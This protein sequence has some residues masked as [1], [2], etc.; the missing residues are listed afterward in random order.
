MTEKEEVVGYIRDNLEKG[1]TKDQ[2]EVSLF[3]S[4]R[5][6]EGLIRRQILEIPDVKLFDAHK[7]AHYALIV[8]T[9]ISLAVR[10]Q[11]AFLEGSEFSKGFGVVAIFIS[12]ILPAIFLVGLIK[13][14]VWGYLFFS[15]F[16]ILNLF[17]SLSGL[18]LVL[19]EEVPFGE[20][21]VITIPWSFFVG[22]ISYLA[23]AIFGIYCWKKIHPEYKLK[24]LFVVSR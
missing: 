17:F 10:I 8:F 21:E 12:L 4:N 6:P 20:V 24:N 1:Y 19:S 23:L 7:K 15:V 14:R 2:I 5:Y 22:L 11:S 13:A 9:F 18:L 16:G 3:Q